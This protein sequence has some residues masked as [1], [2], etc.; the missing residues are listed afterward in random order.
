MDSEELVEWVVAA[1]A[2][3]E[4]CWDTG[5]E[6]NVSVM[7]TQQVRA[8]EYSLTLVPPAGNAT[9]TIS[10]LLGQDLPCETHPRAAARSSGPLLLLDEVG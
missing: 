9:G 2:L 7:A 1:P 6:R 4:F 8:W 5:A 10:I 3:C